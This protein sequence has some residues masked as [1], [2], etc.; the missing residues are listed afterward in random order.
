M[1]NLA[2]RASILMMIIVLA[3]VIAALDDAKQ[4][5]SLSGVVLVLLSR[6][7]GS[8]LAPLVQRAVTALPFDRPITVSGQLE[9]GYQLDNETGFVSLV[10]IMAD[11]LAEAN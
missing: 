10:R 9:L 8:C 3:G 6:P 1:T 7:S 2:K 4:D 11:S 5:G